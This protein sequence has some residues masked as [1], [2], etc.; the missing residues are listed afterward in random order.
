MM[1]YFNFK[2]WGASSYAGSKGVNLAPHIEEARRHFCLSAVE[3]K[4]WKKKVK[5][6]PSL[7]KELGKLHPQYGPPIT[8]R[9]SDQER[10]EALFRP[11]QVDD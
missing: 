5:K 8:A 2:S 11:T 4:V 9:L 1:F 3:K 10:A 6:D 7:K